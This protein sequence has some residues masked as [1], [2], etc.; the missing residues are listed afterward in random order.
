VLRRRADT[1]RAEFPM[2]RAR[3]AITQIALV[4]SLAR[5]RPL[6]ARMTSAQ[7]VSDVVVAHHAQK[8]SLRSGSPSLRQTLAIAWPRPSGPQ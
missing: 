7:Y 2:P 4:T 5:S 8:R 6:G 3:A 1:C